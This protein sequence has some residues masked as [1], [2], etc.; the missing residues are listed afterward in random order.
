LPLAKEM[1]WFVS[2]IVEMLSG[3]DEEVDL[4]AEA[5]T[6]LHKISPILEDVAFRGLLNT[7]GWDWSNR[8]K[9]D[10][11]FYR[12]SDKD[13]S[14]KDQIF[15]YIQ[16][17]LGAILGTGVK[18]GRGIMTMKQGSKEN[19]DHKFVKGLAAALPKSLA[20]PTKAFY[21][22]LHGERDYKGNELMP[23]S[24]FTEGV[25]P[26]WRTVVQTMGFS[27]SALTDIY[28]L[29]NA[30]KNTVGKV[31]VKRKLLMTRFYN[32]QE[33][34]ISTDGVINDIEAFNDM[35]PEKAI[36][37]E[38]L[39]KGLKARAYRT[40]RTEQGTYL[41]DKDREQADKINF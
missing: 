40:D 34:N 39:V 20:D 32:L 33:K 17:I 3:D 1:F 22:T 36:L 14:D 18:I 26:V 24:D 23:Q 30:K 38:Q 2:S 5:R 29:N 35:F 37:N 41:T 15:H 9:L 4:L 27:P 16:E 31:D 21:R 11:L 28:D 13:M 10:G 19:D 25:A 6:E 12:S 8:I 7:L